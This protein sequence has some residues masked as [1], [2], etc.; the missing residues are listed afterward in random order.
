MDYDLL[1]TKLY[2][3]TVYSSGLKTDTVKEGIAFPDYTAT[4]FATWDLV[5]YD[6][7]TAIPQGFYWKYNVIPAQGTGFKVRSYPFTSTESI[8]KNVLEVEVHGD[9]NAYDDAAEPHWLSFELSTDDPN[10]GG[11]KF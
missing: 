10:T 9:W 5:Q 1:T 3:V 2:E 11:T 4:T 8:T 6:A 7:N